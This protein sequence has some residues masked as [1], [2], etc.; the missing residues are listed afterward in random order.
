MSELVHSILHNRLFASIRLPSFAGS[1]LPERMRS[2]AFA[3]LGLT[4]AAG[5]ALV[6]IFAQ[7]S[8]PLLEP[9]PLP[10]EPTVSESIGGAEKATLDRNPVSVRPAHPA[11]SSR[12]EQA[13][14]D[15]SSSAGTADSPAETPVVTQPGGAV[16]P[17]PA[18]APGPSSGDKN[19]GGAVGDEPGGGSSP[20]PTAASEPAPTSP[21][22][23]APA[24]QP[25]SPVP[26]PVISPPPPEPVAPGN[27]L[28]SAAA[29]HASERG[30]EASASNGHT[31]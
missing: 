15:P 21:P 23:P 27:S 3:L 24:S 12:V 13:S 6:A 14:P 20:A 8:F 1:G 16:A 19:G 25:A 10:D 26:V 28:S 17:A 2:T 5:L 29:S 18:A 11:R 30:V 31:E 22:A 7:L 9:A 4:A